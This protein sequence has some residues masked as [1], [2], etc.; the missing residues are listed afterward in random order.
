MGVPGGKGPWLKQGPIKFLCPVPGY[1]RHFG[2]LENL[3]IGMIPVP[4]NEHGPDMDVVQSLVAKD[5]SIKGIFC[6]PKYSNPTGTVYS[7]DVIDALATMKTAAPDFRIFWDNA[8]AVHHLGEGP[9][10]IKSILQACDAGGNPN[11]AFVFASTSKISFAGAGISFMAQ[12][13]DNLVET[14]K[15]LGK[16]TIGPDKLNILRH[17]Q[18]FK[19]YDGILAHM[20]RH[21]AILKPKFDVIQSTFD[22]A[23]EGTGICTYTNPKGGYFVS[24]DTLPGKAKKTVKLAEGLGLKLTNAGATFPKGEDPEDRNIRI[25]PSLPPLE[26]VKQAMEMITVCI[27]L[28][29]LD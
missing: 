19:N 4:L 6:V 21:A 7:D 26:E 22:A 8:Y 25:A 13:Q 18:F 10:P 9:T 1:D 14:K 12:S 15:R 3:G 11:R 29:S 24:L 20:D 27:K 5:A 28:A 23:F 17:V 16:Q 2:I